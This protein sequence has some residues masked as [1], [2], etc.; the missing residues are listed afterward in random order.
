[1]QP[2]IFTG[3]TNDMTIAREEIF[4]PVLSVIRYSSV[5]EAIAIANDTEY[6]LSAGVWSNDNERALEVAEQLEA[7]TVWINDWHMVSC[8]YPF[9]GYKQSGFGR[10]LGPHALDEYTEEK[11]IHL[12]LSGRRDRRVYD[13]I[14]PRRE[15]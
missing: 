2:T 11:F 9:G 15:T 4:G 14:V 3:V 12:D 10:E 7:G 5:E 8:E 1:V 13:L 6:G